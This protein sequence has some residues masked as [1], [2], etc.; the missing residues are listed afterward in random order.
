MRLFWRRK[1][2]RPNVWPVHDDIGGAESRLHRLR[3]GF[4]KISGHW[5][6]S[7]RFPNFYRSI[8]FSATA[9]I[10]SFALIFY[11]LSSPRPIALA[12]NLFEPETIAGRASVID[13]DTIEIHG[14]RIRLFGI[15]A[16]ESDQDCLVGG[17]PTRCGQRAALA[18][19]DEI[20]NRPVTCDSKDRDS[21]GRVVAI[22][23]VA[24][25]D[26]NAW[27]VAQ[28]WALAYRQYS[29][30][31]VTQERQAAASK[32]GI[33]QGEFVSPWD[34]RRDHARALPS[35]PP[36]NGAA[37]I[38]ARNSSA[39][40]GQCDIKGNISQNGERIYHVPG[41]GY[42]SRTIIDLAKGERWFCSE[43]EARAAGWRR[44]RR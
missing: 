4:S 2:P 31:Y 33:W 10:G 23:R 11:L 8:I 7:S 9:A 20:N 27:M 37:S 13:G 16:P 25:E 26:L 34:W 38:S 14:T 1:S 15:D 3:R 28:G 29:T 41:G 19:A 40:T 6:R 42:Y 44:S 18:L 24:G 32:R 12:P 36:P 39:P 30:D 21:Y 35:T 17:H 43:A 5:D 22:C